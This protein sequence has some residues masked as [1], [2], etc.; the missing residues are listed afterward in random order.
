MTIPEAGG[1]SRSGRHAR[2]VAIVMGFAAI[3][4]PALASDRDLQRVLLESGCIA[5]GIEIVLQ[6]RDLVAYRANCL[7][8]SH[9]SLVIACSGGRCT[10]SPRSTTAIPDKSRLTFP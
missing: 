1:R 3:G 4:S 5:P 6:Q 7:G 9:R 10:P 8:P 2:I